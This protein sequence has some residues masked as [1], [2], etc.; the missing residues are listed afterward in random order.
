[1]NKFMGYQSSF[2]Y[3][4]DGDLILTAEETSYKVHRSILTTASK[5]FQDMFN[6][7]QLSPEQLIPEIP[8]IDSPIELE[9][10]LSQIYS[11]STLNLTWKEVAILLQIADKY[12]V[13]KAFQGCLQW[14]ELH[15]YEDPLLA[16]VFSESGK[17]RKV[18]KESSKLVLENLSKFERF[19]HFQRLSHNTQVKLYRRIFKYKKSID[20]INSKI[21][22]SHF[23][24]GHTT[25][26]PHPGTHD[27]ELDYE[28]KLRMEYIKKPPLLS[29][30]EAHRILFFDLF[31]TS[32]EYCQ[33][34]V[35][36]RPLQKAFEEHIGKYEEVEIYGTRG[37]EF[38][39]RKYIFI[40]M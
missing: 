18:Y 25:S 33:G 27:E 5:I 37:I 13:E 35:V 24:S 11:P 39:G 9:L 30:S 6:H 29:P 7:A 12:E 21:K 28:V 38:N 32:P 3:Y 36:C 19:P 15:F 34:H 14:L 10:L 23:F 31:Q 4:H 20:E 2:H 40:E 8:L 1:M 17:F 26:C 22:F 16:L